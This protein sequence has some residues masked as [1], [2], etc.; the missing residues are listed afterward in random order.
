MKIF[1]SAI[2]TITGKLL[3]FITVLLLIILGFFIYVAIS[4][5]NNTSYK[6][7][8]HDAKLTAISMLSGLNEMMLNGSITNTANRKQV[9]SLF[10]KTRGISNFKFIRGNPVNK[11][12]GAGLAIEQPVS[13]W[14]GK[15]LKSHKTISRIFVKN[16]NKF[17]QIGIPL[18]AKKNERGIDC[19]MCHSVPDNTVLGG[20]SFVYSLKKADYYSGIF[21][22]NAIIFLIVSIIIICL[23]IFFI[24]KRTLSR[25]VDEFSKKF[26]QLADGDLSLKF[27]AKKFEGSELGIIALVANAVIYNLSRSVSGF[28]S[29]HLST[30]DS[31]ITTKVMASKFK[32]DIEDSVS[33][34][35]SV[36]AAIDEMSRSA[37]EISSNAHV[38]QDEAKENS[39]FTVNGIKALQALEGKIKVEEQCMKSISETVNRFIEKTKTI[40]DLTEKVKE[41]AAQTNLLSLNAAIEAARAGEHGRGFAV[42]ADEV[43]TLAD[44]SAMAAK[45]IEIVTL[46]VAN[47]SGEVIERINEGFAHITDSVQFSED[48]LNVIMDVAVS[49]DKTN[50]KVT[51]IASAAEEQSQVSRE[52]AENISNIADLVEK[53]EKSFADVESEVEGVF[54]RTASSVSSFARWKSDYITLNITKMDHLIW[55]S[56]VMDVLVGN[57][58]MNPSELSDHHQC[59]LG[60]WYYGPEGSKYENVPEFVELG[61][62]HPLVHKTGKAVVEAANSGDKKGAY[63]LVKTLEEYKASVISALDKLCEKIVENNQE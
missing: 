2:R 4:V 52:M 58:T 15:I 48:T 51:Q 16:G 47:Q 29:D 26:G 55:V 35:T 3:I 44:K 41:I 27:D 17:I 20:I 59:R 43:R 54:N 57:I 37:D 28:V 50:D 19:L 9:F 45:E 49:A 25:P 56:K 38:A 18:I 7:V 53:M 5:Q 62:I 8:T 23:G 24:L 31:A 46:E 42:V 11:Q 14:D 30:L 33:K 22:R 39:V 12:F 13:E 6:M 10:N 1:E 32:D 61:K 34:I 36:A 40:T 60:K 21:M 63:E